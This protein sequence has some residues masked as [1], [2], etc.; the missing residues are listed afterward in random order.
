MTAPLIAV[1]PLGNGQYAVDFK[2]TN[3]IKSGPFDQAL[4]SM[5]ALSAHLSNLEKKQTV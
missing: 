2:G 1:R 5:R 3:V 4:S